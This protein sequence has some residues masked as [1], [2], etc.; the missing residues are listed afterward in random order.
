MV[1]SAFTGRE[2]ASQTKILVQTPMT[3]AG[4]QQYCRKSHSDLVR[5]RSLAENEEIRSLV[6]AGMLVWIGLFGDSWKWSDG[7]NTFFRYWQQ[8]QAGSS[9]E[10]PN[11]AQVNGGAWRGK[12]CD[13]KSTFLCYRKCTSV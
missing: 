9:V 7:R 6:P 1:I 3:W 12:S 5:V 8:E 4:A 2:G 11:C 10:G 13:S